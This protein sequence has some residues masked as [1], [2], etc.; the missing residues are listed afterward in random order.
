[1]TELSTHVGVGL[2]WDDT[3]KLIDADFGT[4]AGEVCEGNDSRLTDDRTASGIRTASTVVVVSAAT[5]PT[6]GQVLQATSSTAAAWATLSGSAP[7]TQIDETSGPTTLNVGAIT[8]L[9]LTRRNGTSFEGVT[10]SATLVGLAN[11]TNDAQLKRSAGDF[12][13]FS[14]KAIPTTSDVLIIE[15]AAAAG[16]KKYVTINQLPALAPAAHASSHLPGGSDALTTAVAGAIQ[17]DDAAS[18]GVAAS[19][20]RSDHK[21]SIVAAVA[22]SI[23][24]DDAAAEGVATSFSRSDHTH[25]ITC[26]AASANPPGTASA[27]GSASSFARSDHTHTLAAF[28]TGGTNFCVG[29]DSRL[30]D[31]RTASGLRTASTVVVVSAAT[32]PSSGQVLTATSTT[33]AT[34][35]TPSSTPF[36]TWYYY[37]D[38]LENPVTSDWAINSLA[39]VS[40][41]T[42][43]S[44]FNVRR[45]A[46]A[47][48]NGVGASVVIPLTATNI[49]FGFTSRAETTPA[50]TV[51]VV[52][53]VYVRELNATVESWS[54]GTDLTALSFGT[55]E[56]WE[57][58]SQ[59]VA[60]STLSLVAGRRL[61]IELT[62]RG[63]DG[64]DTLTTDWT[65]L[66]FSV[67]FS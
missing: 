2:E 47:T 34:W 3:G 33:A 56:N 23:L 45:F 64:S 1:M 49:I 27:E 57:D 46:N 55:N 22:G 29:N 4:G 38:Q 13:T 53:R 20:S 41:C 50:G 67:G 7:A 66:L 5:A 26:A 11:V 24:P 8:D 17:P 12:S 59:T 42:N 14:N 58:D 30:S 6:N 18:A 65:L 28:G 36:T 10:A 40:A 61:Q 54:A 63:S 16:A 44:G 48:E 9:Q 37:A 52:P 43:N 31:D 35:Q 25:A 15:D 32:A 19:F 60:L 62:R 51:A 21:H 39:A